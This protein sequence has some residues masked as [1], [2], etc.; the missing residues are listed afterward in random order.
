MTTIACSLP[1]RETAGGGGSSATTGAGESSSAAWV[2][3]VAEMPA[4]S[5]RAAGQAEVGPR[6]GDVI[7]ANIGSP[8]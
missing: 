6:L 1:R 4:G 5:G 7:E 8:D 3:S 2:P